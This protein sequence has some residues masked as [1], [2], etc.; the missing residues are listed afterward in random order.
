MDESIGAIEVGRYA[1]L[2][3]LD[4]K[5]LDDISATRNAIAAVYKDGERVETV[6]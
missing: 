1:D 5:P 3:A 4:E 2:V 6:A